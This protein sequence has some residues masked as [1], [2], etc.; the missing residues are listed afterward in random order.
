MLEEITLTA[1]MVRVAAA[2]AV[3][4]LSAVILVRFSKKKAG[5]C[6]AVLVSSLWHPCR[7]VRMFFL[8]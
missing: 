2:L 6:R 5:H 8:Y 4:M 1:Y 7:L 3:M